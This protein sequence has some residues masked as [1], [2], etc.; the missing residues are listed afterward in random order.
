MDGGLGFAQSGKQFFRTILSR[1]AQRRI[2]NQTVDVTER[3]VHV[4]MLFLV[5]LGVDMTMALVMIAMIVLMVTTVAVV[6]TIVVMGVV[7]RSV[8]SLDA[9]LC[10]ANPGAGDPL[11][12]DRGRRNR[13]AAKRSADVLELYASVD[14]RAE[15]HVSGRTGK[16]VEV[17]DLHNLSI[18]LHTPAFAVECAPTRSSSSTS[19]QPG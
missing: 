2:V 1:P 16:A 8:L 14:Q 9:E 10:G 6:A 7:Q 5:R 4:M 18:V 19:D 13:E 3:P 17:Q 11:G 12:P 15:D